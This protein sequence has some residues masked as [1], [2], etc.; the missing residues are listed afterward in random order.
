MNIAAQLEWLLSL[1]ID[2]PD[3]KVLVSIS[4]DKGDGVFS[5]VVQ[6]ESTVSK[7]AEAC[8]QFVQEHNLDGVELHWRYPQAE[9]R[10]QFT[11][12][13]RVSFFV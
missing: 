5:T 10:E 6:A 12:L 7:F 3:L 11:E 9:E 13:L 2:R 8:L 1:K 4:N